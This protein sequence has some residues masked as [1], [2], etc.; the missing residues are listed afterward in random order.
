MLRLRPPGAGGGSEGT[1]GTAPGP[2]VTEL[3]GRL[4]PRG[5]D[6]SLPEWPKRRAWGG[7]QVSCSAWGPGVRLGTEWGPLLHTGVRLS[8]PC[9]RN[10]GFFYWLRPG[11]RNW[12]RPGSWKGRVQVVRGPEVLG[13]G[14]RVRRRTW[15]PRFDSWHPPA[16]PWLFSDTV[17][18]RVSPRLVACQENQRRRGQ[19]VLCVSTGQGLLP[20]ACWVETRR[21]AG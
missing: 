3:S 12:T 11:P 17:L 19:G 14:W 8:V 1:C 16:G 10:L 4:A 18:L 5:V 7:A 21:G 2:P 9:V 13:R 20:G 15:A 6:G